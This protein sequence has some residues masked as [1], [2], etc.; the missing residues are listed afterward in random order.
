MPD[1]NPIFEYQ[2]S[3]DHDSASP[4]RHPVVI[5]GAGPVG[6]TLAI[7][8]AL[9]QVPVVLLE[10]LNTISD[11]SRAICFAKRTLEICKRLGMG[12]RLLDKGVTWKTGKVFLG[13]DQLFEFD[14]LPE[15]GH[16]FPAFINLQQYYME[17]YAIDRALELKEFIDLRWFSELKGIESMEEGVRLT[18]STPDGSYQVDC[19][20]LIAADGARSFCRKALGLEFQG[21]T[22]DDQFLIAD[23]KTKTD[24]PPVRRFWF[25][26]TF[27][28]AASALLHMQPDD[29]WRL[30]FQIGLEADAEEETRSENVMRRVRGMLGDEIEAEMEWISLYKFHSRSIRNFRHGRVIF[31]GDAAHQVSPF[32]ARGANSGIQDAENLAWK[33]QLVLKELAPEILLDSYNAERTYAAEENVRHSTQSTDFIVPKGE[34][35]LVFR[36][37][38]LSLAK[39]YKFAIPLINTGRL[40]TPTIHRESPLNTPDCDSWSGKL[41]PG[42]PAVDAPVHTTKGKRWLLDQLKGE[43][44]L[45]YFTDGTVPEDVEAELRRLSE[46]A[47]L[48]K[49]LV[50]G[51]NSESQG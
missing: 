41:L 43:F 46:N 33:L 49:P 32:G 26:P 35:S 45:L 30:D 19:D 3:P 36:N 21:R 20:W 5:A 23:I 48:V 2:H 44:T 34:V 10:A 8:L 17:L 25:A 24:M 42:A 27:T 12:R 29:V 40:S 16:Q 51:L 22:F 13:D 38:V 47:V 37:A 4:V 28:D 9:K 7:D 1:D 50:I 15:D 18:V 14:L 6:L 39:E 11:G 31:T